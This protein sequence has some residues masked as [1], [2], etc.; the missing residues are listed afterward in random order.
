MGYTQFPALGCR[1]GGT[2]LSK[3][4]SVSWPIS[5]VLAMRIVWRCIGWKLYCNGVDLCGLGL[6]KFPR[7]L[8][9]TCSFVWN[10]DIWCRF[11]AIWGNTVPFSHSRS[12]LKTSRRFGA[13]VKQQLLATWAGKK[14][15]ES[16]GGW[17]FHGTGTVCCEMVVDE[18]VGCMA[19][20]AVL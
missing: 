10:I 1:A 17:R 5:S 6:C 4:G 15:R 3:T 13:S 2:S 8:W 20:V 12:L 9:D 18:L 19:L 14:Y 16:I 11:D 7:C